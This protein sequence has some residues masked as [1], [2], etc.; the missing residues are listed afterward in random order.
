MAV[1]TSTGDQRV[2]RAGRSAGPSQQGQRSDGIK[3]SSSAPQ[4][5]PTV[6]GS[7]RTAP[8]TRA[9]SGPAIRA[10]RGRS[11]R[12]RPPG[13]RAPSRRSEARP[14][15]P[16]RQHP[17]PPAPR[18]LLHQATPSGVPV[19]GVP[20]HRP[21]WLRL[22]RQ[23]SATA[24]KLGGMNAVAPRKAGAQPTPIS[25]CP[26]GERAVAVAT[27]DS[28]APAIA[29][30][31]ATSKVRRCPEIDGDARESCMVPKA[32]AEGPRPTR[33][34]PTAKLRLQPRGRGGGDGAKRLAQ[35]KAADQRQR[36]GPGLWGSLTVKV[37][38][39]G[40]AEGRLMPQA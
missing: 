14:V 17:K 21:P 6:C 16:A 8:R 33:A 12:H 24:P 15:P 39:Q 35:R 34:W 27:A 2:S 19:N 7:R 36:R 5:M 11:C 26:G 28:A 29:I 10:L 40:L 30:G 38:Q 4:Q 31:N 3:A 18:R 37:V 23:R 20:A 13:A 22:T 1:A 25:A 32:N 9:P